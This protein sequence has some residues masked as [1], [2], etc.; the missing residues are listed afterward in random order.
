VWGAGHAAELAYI[1]P[2]FNN[3]TPIAPLFDPAERRLAREMTQ[4]WGGFTRYGKPR[5][6]DQ[7]TWPRYTRHSKKHGRV[8]SLRAGGRTKVISDKTY[9]A[10]HQCGF[11]STMPVIDVTA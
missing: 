3:G 1:W 10:E 5:A 7:T 4:Y 11:W 6:A 9:S 8:L 2:S